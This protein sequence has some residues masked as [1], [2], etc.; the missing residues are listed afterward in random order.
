M[1]I[2]ITLGSA[3]WIAG[4]C[5]LSARGAAPSDQPHSIGALPEVEVIATPLPENDWRRERLPAPLQTADAADIASSHAVDLSEYLNRRLGGVF[6]NDAQNNPLQ[7]DVNYRGYTA[8]PLLGEPQGLAVYMDGVRLNQPF[9]DIVSWDLIPRSA[10]AAITLVPGSN[11]LFGLNA[12]GGALSIRTKD[13]RANAGADVHA[14]YG[15]HARRTLEFEYGDFTTAGFDWFVTG[16]AFR[17]GGWRDASPTTS[18][19]L[20]GKLG[21]RGDAAELALTAAYARSD[22]TGNGTQEQRFLR[23]DYKSIYTKPD[24]TDNRSW[25]LNAT[26]AKRF[27]A[28]SLRGNAYYRNLD[29]ATFNGDLNDDALNQPLYQPDAM[30]Q[31]ALAAAGYSGFPASGENATTAP[32]P[33]WRCL[34]N[35]LLNTAP[36]ELC[37]GLL[38]R[39]RSEQ[40]VAGLSAQWSLQ[41]QWFKRDNRLVA[42]A[43]YEASAAHFEQST[44]FAYLNADRSFTPVAGPGAFADGSQTS[45][46]AFDARVALHGRTRNWSAYIADAIELRERLRLTVSG[47]FN[48]TRIVNRDALAPGQPGSLDGDHTFSRFN[49]GAG[50]IWQS[51]ANINAYAGY[52]QSNRA[53]SAIE[54][55][56]ADPNNPCKL[57]NAM[58]SDPPL[59]QVIA[60]T[61]EVGVRS[62]AGDAGYWSLGVFRTDNL[63]DI[64]F[65]ADD[66][67]GFGYFAN[68]GRTRRQGV[69]AGFSRRMGAVEVG[70]NYAYLDATY[71]SALT[72]NGAANSANDA[73]LAGAPGFDGVIDVEPGARIPLIPRHVFKTFVEYTF[74]ARLSASIEMLARSRAYARGNENNLHQPDGVYYLGPGETSGYALF[75]MSLDYRP[76]NALQLYLQV[77]NV[78]DRRYATAAQLGA[79]GFNANG[80][81][82]AQPFAAPVVDGELP[83]VHATF[84]SPGAPRAFSLGVRYRLDTRR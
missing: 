2:R 83:I 71:R 69:E 50:L 29:G 23:D 66:Q 32:Y 75:N 20:F 39:T 53:P 73:A 55:G 25:L 65:V 84:F 44:Q 74:D 58:S 22:L 17:D 72:L 28:A 82:I 9:G 27:D 31:S 68:I 42:G 5:C 34:A 30:E 51:A 15:S 6:I 77:D 11:P 8:S 19:Q 24:I 43:A 61:T 48:R 54:L 46:D 52:S 12:L 35:T 16:A 78:F 79:T 60:R 57:P 10:I 80:A 47:R 41:H 7:P 37:N 45:A 1:I 18:N 33:F 13:G 59:N 64:L 67:S 3:L 63:D 36:N 49:P 26:I 56:C 76:T 4:A 70:G 40:R 21:W 14:Y 38:N 62:A 81:F